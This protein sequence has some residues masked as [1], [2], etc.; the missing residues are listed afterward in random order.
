MKKIFAIA[1][2]LC[3]AL[4]LSM[5]A[6]AANSPTPDRP[7]VPAPNTSAGT[8]AGDKFSY[9][10]TDSQGRNIR[11]TVDILDSRDKD[12]NDLVAE[13]TSSFGNAKI[14]N[15]YRV[16]INTAIDDNETVTL[17][18]Y[19][20]GVTNDSVVLV[21]D[22]WEVFDNVTIGANGNRAIITAPASVYKTWKYYAVVNGVDVVVVDTPQ[23]DIQQDEEEED[24]NETPDV[25]AEDDEP[26]TVEPEVPADNNPGTGIAL[27]VVPMIVAVAAIVVSKKR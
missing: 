27:A 17:N 2:A 1:L 18:V 7:S 24:V 20:P 6:F 19:A 13:L 9:S 26:E 4:S 14:V 15:L 23:E 11:V 22:E 8:S 5:T 3:L 12:Y 16:T 21:Y 25:D 10:A